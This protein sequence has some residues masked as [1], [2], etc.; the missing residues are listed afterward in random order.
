MILRSVYFI[1]KFRIFIPGQTDLNKLKVKCCRLEI[2]VYMQVSYQLL[3]CNYVSAHSFSIY[4]ANIRKTPTIFH[5]KF[6]RVIGTDD[7]TVCLLYSEISNFHS[8][9]MGL[10]SSKQAIINC[11]KQTSLRSTFV[12]RIDRW[13]VYTGQINKDFL[14]WDVHIRQEIKSCPMLRK[15]HAFF[16]FYFQFLHIKECIKCSIYYKL[17]KTNLLEINLCVQNRQVIGL[18]R[19]N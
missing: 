2:A 6:H 4:S 18:Y 14:H 16:F 9:V 13:L 1:V 10:Y 5:F 12:F 19:S 15:C 7:L 17:S 3:K 11:L 8:R